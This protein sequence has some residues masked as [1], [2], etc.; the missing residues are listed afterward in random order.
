MT[1]VII[2]GA[3]LM[4]RWHADT[5]VKAGARVVAIVDPDESRAAALSAA[6]RECRGTA[7]LDEAL[8]LAEVVH[9]CSPTPTHAPLAR[10]ALEAGRHVLVEK[11]VAETASETAALVDAAGAK[12]LVFCPVH[13]FLFQD[14][15]LR[16]LDELA[17]I[18]PLQHVRFTMCSAG[19]DRED[20]AGRDRV[21]LEILPHPLS[22]LA[23]LTP[24]RVSAATWSI[25]HPAAGEILAVTEVGAVTAS[26]LVSMR[27]RPTT[28]RMELIGSGGAI[29]ADLFH[30]FS[31]TL[32]GAVSRARKITHPLTHAAQVAGTAS[33]NLVRRASRR[34]PAYPGLRRLFE[35]FYAAAAGTGTAPIAAAEILDVVEACDSLTRMVR[36]R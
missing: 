16:A 23:R 10:L 18:G 36:E 24:G 28:N 2:V 26:I 25:R 4:G 8:G 30:G 15:V 11:P 6:Y 33:S 35:L 9:I 32:D 13:Q 1:R 5:A 22:L 27:G 14:G 29:E 21:A 7:R 3:G 34:E 17:R 12:G 31:V 19:A 20:D